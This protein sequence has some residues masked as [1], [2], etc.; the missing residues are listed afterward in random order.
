MI[1]SDENAGH[2][3]N[4]V[5]IN[6]CCRKTS[7]PTHIHGQ[8]VPDWYNEIADTK[9]KRIKRMHWREWAE[10]QQKRDNQRVLSRDELKARNYQT[11]LIRRKRDAAYRLLQKNRQEKIEKAKHTIG[12]ITYNRSRHF[13]NHRLNKIRKYVKSRDEALASAQRRANYRS[14]IRR[15]IEM[16]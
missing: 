16:L 1:I 13:K 15:E 14:K 4:F 3:T 7:L 8:L 6:I 5:I 12:K 9:A 11:A 10:A 2:G